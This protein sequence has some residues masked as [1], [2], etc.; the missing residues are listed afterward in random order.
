MKDK[1]AIDFLV[2]KIGSH[3][4]VADALD[5]TPQVLTNWRTRGISH[6][7]RAKV[8]AMIND[9]GRHLPREWLMERS[10]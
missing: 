5:I 2:S 10:P 9:N 8:W 1:K 6:A 7:Q 4:A 3:K